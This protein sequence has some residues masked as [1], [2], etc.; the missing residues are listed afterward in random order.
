MVIAKLIL[1]SFILD[2][3]FA[4]KFRNYLISVNFPYFTRLIRAFVLPAH[5][6]IISLKF[7][8]NPIIAPA[9]YVFVYA[10]MYEYIHAYINVKRMVSLSVGLDLKMGEAVTTVVHH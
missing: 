1:K 2:A 8:R 4:H 3:P 7:G 6:N 9:Y 5:F 10:C